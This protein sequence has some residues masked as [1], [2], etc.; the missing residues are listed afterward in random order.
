[1]LVKIDLRDCRYFESLI[2]S[3]PYPT[4]FVMNPIWLAKG[5]YFTHSESGFLVIVK[6]SQMFGRKIIYALGSPIFLGGGSSEK[7]RRQEARA[8]HRLRKRLDFQLTD[9]EV[10]FLECC[11]V[12]KQKISREFLYRNQDYRQ[13]SG[14]RWSRWRQV[15]NRVEKEY[16]TRVFH[17]ELPLT[18]QVQMKGVL[19]SWKVDRLNQVGRHSRWYIDHMAELED[20]LVLC[21]Y[22]KAG[23]LTSF[24]TSQNIGGYIY[25]LDEKASRSVKPLRNGARAHH[26]LTETRKVECS[27][28]IVTS[29][30]WGPAGRSTF[31]KQEHTLGHQG[32]LLFTRIRRLL[33]TYE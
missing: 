11:G 4:T 3:R 5:P 30:P 1:M 19:K 8:F 6:K 31:T 16:E 17:N 7:R 25:I 27:T 33:L 20:Y 14:R 2:S 15:L 10:E 9:Y 18:L 22:D 28:S 23:D 24:T 26:L 21:F 29:A 12:R 32:R 13:L